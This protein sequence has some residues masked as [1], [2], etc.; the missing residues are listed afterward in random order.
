MFLKFNIK[1][2][3]FTSKNISL[4]IRKIMCG[5]L[6]C[7]EVRRGKLETYKV[8]CHRRMM[9]ISWVDK[10]TNEEVFLRTG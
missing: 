2:K 6:F 7:K 10:V 8:W 4:Q 5:V 1:K 3:I 9:R